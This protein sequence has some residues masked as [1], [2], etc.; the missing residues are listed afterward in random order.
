MPESRFCILLVDDSEVNQEIWPPLLE[1]EGYRVLSAYDGQEALRLMDEEPVDLVLLDVVMP[2]M[3]GFEVLGALRREY[4][5]TDI[6]VIMATSKDQS[7]DVVKAFNLGVNDYVTKPL[8]LHV[9]LARIQAQ[10]RTRVPRSEYQGTAEGESVDGPEIGP[11]TVL[12]GKYR[13]ESLIGRGNF[14]AVYRAEH[15]KLRRPVAVKVLRTRFNTDRVSLAR[16][17]QEGISLSRL[18]HPSA[19]AVLDLSVTEDDVTYLVMELLRGHSLEEE[20]KRNG[21]LS[22]ARC[23]EILFPIC[24]VLAEAHGV[25]IIH[26]DIKPQNIFLHQGRREEVVKVLDFGIAKLVGESEIK[27]QLTLEGNSVGTPAYMAP[28]R[29]T[30]DPY[31]GRADVYSVAVMLY[32]MLTGRTPFAHAD[33]NF[34]KLIRMHVVER[35]KPLR[36]FDPD[37]P[38]EV[39]DVVLGALAKESVDRPGA[40]ELAVRYAAA[41]HLPLPA[42]AVP[43][44]DRPE[45]PTDLEELPPLGSEPTLEWKKE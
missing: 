19:V 30:N 32:E 44:K 34:F 18:H 25:G 11:G 28:E 27:Q 42:P 14:G 9:T 4:G 26:R 40:H 24:D 6:P 33:G 1:S 45:V 7:E 16:F 15:L 43:P 41:T 36:A 35:P 5:A 23:G 22:P 29:F 3:S 21:P 37:I 39:E 2:G 8:D 31:D 17:Q 38:K 10:L 20:L 13:L 12:E